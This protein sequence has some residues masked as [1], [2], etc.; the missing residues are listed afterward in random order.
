MNL[1]FLFLALI[2][3][4]C[5]PSGSAQIEVKQDGTTTFSGLAMTM[6]YNI[7]IGQ[8]LTPDQTAQVAGII[9]QGFQDTD[10]IYNKWNP[11][12][13]LSRLN[14]Q[15]AGIST[16]LSPLLQRLFEE[17][18]AVVILSR[19]K[20][21]P[22]IEPLQHLWK[23]KLNS[24]MIPD[25]QEIAAVAPAIGWKNISFDNGVFRKEHDLTQMDFGGIAKGLCIDLLI[26]RLNE[27]GFS[28]VFIEWGGEIRAS[29]NHP[30]GRPWTVYISRFGDSNPDHAIAT[31]HLENQAVA[32]SG[33][34]LQNW[35]IR[36]DDQQEKRTIIYFHIFDPETLQPLE[37]THLSVASASVVAPSCALA[38]GLATIPLLFSSLEE[39]T[40]WAEEIKEKF[41][42]LSFWIVSR[43][44][45][46]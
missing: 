11:H 26:E 23:E 39:A 37:A 14:K 20:F 38:D 36:K 18:N 13:E 19:G 24:G 22:T 31:L 34:Y 2:V 7:L 16:P 32:T 28:H 3:S 8:P 27:V 42:D 1:I 29:G 25:K 46:M 35:T 6:S 5:Q 17:A 40:I 33:D 30:E 10:D 45:K 41:P 15:K 9:Q 21:D 44:V 4:A 43:N 12:S